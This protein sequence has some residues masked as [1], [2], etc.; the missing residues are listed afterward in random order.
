MTQTRV[1]RRIQAARESVY[2]ALVDAAAVAAWRVPEGMTATVH[3]FDARVGGRFRISLTYEAPD[4]HGKTVAAT[5]T[6]HGRF[7]ELVP[8]E[9]VVE[10]L[11]FETSD[12]AMGGLMRMTTTL[13]DADGGT[14]VVVIHD[15]IP[16]GVSVADNEIGTEMALGKLAALVEPN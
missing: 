3:E 1:V 4:R 9:R 6:Y 10:E 2:R 14:S 5:D 16:P 11:E 8:D 7:V 12:P 13:V 15:G